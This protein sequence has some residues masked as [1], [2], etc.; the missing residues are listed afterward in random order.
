MLT[1]LLMHYGYTVSNTS[2]FHLIS[3][4]CVSLKWS[5]LLCILFSFPFFFLSSGICLITPT[6]LVLQTSVCTDLYYN[7]RGNRHPNNFLQLELIVALVNVLECGYF[8]NKCLYCIISAFWCL[9]RASWSQQIPSLN[10]TFKAQRLRLILLQ[11]S[12]IV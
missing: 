4:T 2:T 9:F 8:A 12:L 11:Q 5:F 6:A 10:C 1:E 3:V 7:F